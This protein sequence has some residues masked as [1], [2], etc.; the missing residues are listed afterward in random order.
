MSLWSALFR[1]A[2]KADV[3]R[4]VTQLVDRA[5]WRRAAAQSELKHFIEPGD[6]WIRDEAAKQQDQDAA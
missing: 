6:G 3:D 5:A 1:R 4:R 2:R